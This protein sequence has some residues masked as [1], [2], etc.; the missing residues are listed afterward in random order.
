[1]T[2]NYKL[3]I[4]LGVLFIAVMV[5]VMRVQNLAKSYIMPTTANEP[6]LRVGEQYI[7]SSLYNL[8]KLD[9]VVFDHAHELFGEGK[10]VFRL[11]AEAGDTLQ[12]TNGVTHVNG[13]NI[14]QNLELKHGYFMKPGEY[15]EIKSLQDV[16]DSYP[17]ASNLYLVHLPDSFAREKNFE[18]FKKEPGYTD[19]TIEEQYGHPWNAD[20]FGPYVIPEDRFFV[21][22]DNRHN[23]QDSRFIGVINVSKIVG[24]IKNK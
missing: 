9:F 12:I 2:R 5:Y 14:D 4:F 18:S 16:S 10:W 13:E 11:M 8:E 23:A 20:E 6:G 1:M 17:V 19:R 22:G 15:D 7:A 3:L 24:V 21:M